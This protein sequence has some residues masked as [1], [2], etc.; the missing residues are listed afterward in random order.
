M[1]VTHAVEVMFLLGEPH[2]R[3]MVQ[4][5]GKLGD[6]SVHVLTRILFLPFGAPVLEPD[7]DLCFRKSETERQIESLTH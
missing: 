7:F 4:F 3:G 6:G 2:S 5:L 1:S